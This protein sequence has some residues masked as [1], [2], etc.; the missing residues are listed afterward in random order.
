MLAF[1]AVSSYSYCFAVDKA[2][3]L[4]PIMRSALT[5]VYAHSRRNDLFRNLAGVE[6]NYWRITRLPLVDIVFLAFLG[7]FFFYVFFHK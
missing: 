5:V 3:L 6:L 7:M 4:G 2:V 1:F